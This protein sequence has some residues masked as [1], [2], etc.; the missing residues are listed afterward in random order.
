MLIKCPV[1]EQEVDAIFIKTLERDVILHHVEERKRYSYPMPWEYEGGPKVERR[2][3]PHVETLYHVKNL[4]QF[5]EH[6]RGRLGGVL[7]V[8]CPGSGRIVERKFD[9]SKGHG[10]MVGGRLV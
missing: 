10:R 2:E 6:N 3:L 7:H 9:H 1:C 5:S 8:R 4:Y